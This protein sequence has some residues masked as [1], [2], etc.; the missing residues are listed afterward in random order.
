MWSQAAWKMKGL[1]VW[2]SIVDWTTGLV[3]VVHTRCLAVFMNISGTFTLIDGG[4][5]LRVLGTASVWGPSGGSGAAPREGESL[6]ERYHRA[7]ESSKV[8]E[9]QLYSEGQ[10]LTEGVSGIGDC[11]RAPINMHLFRAYPAMHQYS[12]VTPARQKCQVFTYTVLTLPS[13]NYSLQVLLH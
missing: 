9:R 12:W 10:S 2:L 6:A 3:S 13:S 8:T 4:Q 7:S 5:A 11:G 1:S